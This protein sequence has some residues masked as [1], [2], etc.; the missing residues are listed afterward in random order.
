MT[1]RPGEEEAPL[2]I[3]IL[4]DQAKDAELMEYELRTAGF[5]FE[6]RRVSDRPAFEAALEEWSPHIVLAD[7][8]LPSFDGTKA[9]TLVRDSNP[10]LPFI[11]VSGALGEER[12]TRILKEGATD[13]VLKD[14]LSRL[15][16]AVER[17]LE[18]A[19]EKRARLEVEQ[20]LRRSERTQR[21]LLEITNAAVAKLERAELFRALVDSLAHAV[22][23]SRA[24]LALRD[25]D[26]RG[27]LHVFTLQGGA[28]A[29]DDEGD[30][31]SPLRLEGSAF[32]KVIQEREPRIRRDLEED[33]A[34]YE[35]EAQVRALGI[36]S[37]A[38]VPLALKDE[39]LGALA[40]GAELPARYG[41]E[42]ADFLLQ[43]G[44]QLALAVDTTL[45]Y[46][47]VERLRRQ[48][49]LENLY[50]RKEVLEAR[51][52]GEIIGESPAIRRVVEAIEQVA[53]TEATVLVSGES[54]T[55]KELV[56]REI[57]NR[58]ERRR[59]PMITVNCAAI[60]ENLY[61]S[62]FFG[63]T[64]G[65][66]SGAVRDREGR[67]A[68]ARGGTLFM[69]ELGEIPR[70]LQSKLLR[71]LQDGTYQRVG[72]ER[73]QT[74]D[75]RIVAATN[76]DLTREVRAGR[77]RE[78]LFYRLSV[79]PIRIPPLRERKEDIVLLAPHFLEQACRKLNRPDLRLTEA[80]M[81][82][83]Q[84]YDW[85]GNVRELQNTLERGVIT[86][87]GRRP[88]LHIPR[89]SGPASSIQGPDSEPGEDGDPEVVSEAEM[90]RRVRKNILA[91]LEKSGG[92]IY[93][94]GGA[95]E[96]LGIPPTTLASRLKTLEIDPKA[97]AS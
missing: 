69:D 63:H 80:D 73:N 92:K 87:Q 53:P 35:H 50:L 18:E 96:L 55:G 22:E 4:E 49:E 52:F 93:G 5:D 7:Y 46:E 39:V 58:S 64:K 12:A 51:S 47:E 74:A 34:E 66:F 78:D 32:G 25:R 6:A 62:E 90:E 71:V 2:R 60:P 30:E 16:A 42:D 75:V 38:I 61:E 24:S 77:F 67:F 37:Y 15:P 54:G 43:V 48:L 91:A 82:E 26:D 57:H 68:A 86:A 17:A 85:P 20:A 13:Y 10:H 19:E 81:A 56:A 84:A 31:G 21:T 76:R 59:G 36:R 3:L 1:G 65:A 23:F 40:V 8:S 89:T 9:L 33:D 94:E 72:E 97:V 27:L 88:R 41:E 44:R 95:A 11:V 79:F 45:A 14:R 83:L 29:D 70:E 28:G